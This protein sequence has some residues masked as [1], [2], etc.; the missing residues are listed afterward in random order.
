MNKSKFVIALEISAGLIFSFQAICASNAQEKTSL[1]TPT[2]VV[3][4]EAQTV[5]EADVEAET[6]AEVESAVVA[7][8]TKSPAKVQAD[9]EMVT[10]SAKEWAA[11]QED[12]AAV[13]KQLADDKIKAEIKKAEEEKKK[14][15][16]PQN[17]LGGNI[18]WD[19]AFCS[20]DDDCEFAGNSPNDGMKVRQAWIDLRGNWYDMI[21]YRMTYDIANTNI[22]DLWI[23]LYNMPSGLDLKI[24]HMKEPWSSEEL[25]ATEATLFMERSYM[26]N[27]R[28]ICGSRNNGIMVSNWSNA[29]RFSWAA[30]VFASSMKEKTLGCVGEHGHLA[31]T[32]RATYL[33]YF[34][35]NCV[36]QK[37]LLHLGASYSYRHFDQTKASDYGTQCSITGDTAICPAIL[38]TGLLTGLHDMNVV[39]LELYWIRGAF[40]MDVEHSIFFMKDD[41]AGDATVNAGFIEFAYTLTGESRNYRKAG[42]SFGVLKPKNPF[43]RT[44]KDGVGVFTGPGAWEIAYQCSWIDTSDLAAGYSCAANHTGTNGKALANTI[45]L[46]WYLNENMRWM[47]NYS[48]ERVEYEGIGKNGA[49]LS[50]TTGWE[51][52]FGTRVQVT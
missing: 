50:G 18:L 21:N 12:V 32:T 34:E 36:G 30:G 22:K 15:T 23:G 43:I 17:K 19:S 47:F 3:K 41:L 4:A 14:Y 35:E 7:A 16:K 49:D 6:D 37:F 8:E 52:I 48:I 29:D 44:C 24:G 25:T 39:G 10:V 20:L 28:S 2:S 26:N 1:L 5:I 31:F 45:G 13:K 33:P 9:E 11:L 38:N 40:S 42:G 51:H 27:M 46:N